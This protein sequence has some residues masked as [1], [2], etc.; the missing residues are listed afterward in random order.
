MQVSQAVMMILIQRYIVKNIAT[1][2]AKS[3]MHTTGI[4]PDAL[5]TA[6]LTPVYKGNDN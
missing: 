4:M 2:I 3:L 5:K 6:L 1:F